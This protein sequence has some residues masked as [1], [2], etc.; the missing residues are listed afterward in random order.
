MASECIVGLLDDGTVESLRYFQCRRTVLEMLRDR[1]YDIP[2]SELTRSI[3]EFRSLFG[4]EPNPEALRIR[5]SLSTHPFHKVLVVFTGT[6]VVTKA[7]ILG[8]YGQITNEERLNRLIIVVQSKMTAFARKELETCPLEV[9]IIEMNDM[10]F[11]I[12]KHVLQPKY[13]VLTDDEK[14]ALLMKYNVEEKQ[15]PY[16]LKTDPIARYYALRKGQVIKITHKGDLVDSL[17]AYRCVV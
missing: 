4:Q 17:V 15:L 1:G 2:N 5:V 14:R 10:L 16:M 9:E 13:E 7:T 11:N 3:S 6:S 12:T 8:I